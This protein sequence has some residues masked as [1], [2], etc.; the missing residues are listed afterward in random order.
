MPAHD[1]GDR[2]EVGWAACRLPEDGGDLAEVGGPEDAGREDRE[3]PGVDVAGVV[4]AVDDPRWMVSTSPGP[5]SRVSP[6]TVHLRTP[7]SP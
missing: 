7:A 3:R 5:T 6:P 2:R 4:E 1:L